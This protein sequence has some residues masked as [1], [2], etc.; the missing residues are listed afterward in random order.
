MRKFVEDND[1]RPK[2]IFKGVG[3][4]QCRQSGYIG[5]VGIYELL[6]IDDTFREMINT[7]SSQSNMRRV[8]YKS[9]GASLFDDGIR[10]VKQGVTTIEEVLRV[11]QVCN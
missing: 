7:D 10:K 8:F 5:R 6:I 9:D 3:C 1:I 2:E 11:T 4:E